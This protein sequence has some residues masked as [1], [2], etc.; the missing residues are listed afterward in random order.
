MRHSATCFHQKPGGDVFSE[1]QAAGSGWPGFHP[2]HLGWTL[3]L[4]FD[5]GGNLVRDSTRSEHQKDG[6]PKRRW[7]SWLEAQRRHPGTLWLFGAGHTATVNK[8]LTVRQTWPGVGPAFSRKASNEAWNFLWVVGLPDVRFN[9]RRTLEALHHPFCA[10]K[11]R[12][13]SAS[14]PASWAA[15]LPSARGPGLTTLCL[16][17]LELGRRLPAH[18]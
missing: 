14:D 9:T 8:P 11:T 7:P 4:P 3:N 17:G 10:P 1:A 16:N 18:H 13:T 5:V 12:L 6:S 15:A 2:R